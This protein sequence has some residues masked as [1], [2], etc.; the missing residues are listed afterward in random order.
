MKM[1]DSLQDLEDPV[2]DI[3]LDNKAIKVKVGEVVSPVYKI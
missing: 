2:Q 3:V 1:I